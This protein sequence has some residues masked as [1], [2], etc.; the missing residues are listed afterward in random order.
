MI[1]IPQKQPAKQLSGTLN[2][3]KVY[4]FAAQ[5]SND[6]L[7]EWNL[8]SNK[9]SYSARWKSMVGCNNEEI[10]NSPVEWLA[11]VHHAD[12]EKLQ[13]N[14]SACSQGKIDQF[15]M[16][17]SL[18]HKDGKY[19]FMYCRCFAG[20]DDSGKVCYLAGSQTDITQQKQAEAK[21]HYNANYDRLTGLPNRQL[22]I[23]QLK[24]LSSLEFDPN[25]LF[26]VL[27]LDIDCFKSINHNYSHDIGDRLLIEIV[28]KLQS[29]LQSQDIVARLGGD[30]FAILLT[31]FGSI[32]YPSEIAS[33]IQQEF[34]VPIKVDEYSILI[35]I[36]IGVAP[37]DF[38]E[39]GQH[40]HKCYGLIESLQNAEIAMHQ[41]K[42]NGKACNMVFESAV[43]YKNIE[44]C[45]LENELKKAIELEQFE[46]Y[47][48]PIVRLKDRLLVGFE[49]LIRWH[50]PLNG[51]TY[52]SDFIPLAEKTG[53]II[54]IGWWVLRAAC[55][56]M[57]MWQ[58]Q[59]PDT[60]L[61]F[62]SVNIAG[63][64]LSQ[65]YAGDIIAQILQ[66]TGLDPHCLK[67]EITESEII[68]NVNIVLKTA[69][70]LRNLGVQLSMDDFGTGYSSLGY[71][72]SLPVDT[73]KIDR[74]FIQN[75]AIDRSDNA[76]A[77]YHELEIVKTIIKLSEVFDLDV[78]AE[79][80]ENESQCAKLLDL[81]CEYGQGYLFSKPVSSIIAAS[82]L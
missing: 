13:R 47:Y 60:S 1:C 9:I 20:L 3:E 37:L 63:K 70:K 59:H 62:I 67:L 49:A 57:M 74:S 32:N 45:K 27:Y 25:Y 38:T 43:Y 23:R 39:Q 2:C 4:S 46:L 48:Q 51:L 34:S 44:Q 40:R 10:K 22:F 12:L 33:Q 19:R 18:L 36:S 26:G 75:I 5:I 58:Q 11:R 31:D 29:C 76:V 55:E 30:Q 17:Y 56:Q 53:L 66:E 65:P 77:Q 81:Q 50:H 73:L 68:E 41:A 64:Q 78:V 35:T 52:P 16:E 14:L 82:L 7:W 72:H 80:I 42:D 54:P 24:E 28:N 61:T 6:G 79:G 69:E 21:L 15:E 8:N 71:L